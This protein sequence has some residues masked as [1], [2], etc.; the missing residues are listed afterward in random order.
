M[1]NEYVFCPRLFFLEWVDALWASNADVEEGLHRHRRVDSGGG[2]APLPSEGTLVAAR[3]VKLASEALGISAKLDLVEGVAGGVVP[4]DTKKG[5]PQADGTA[6]E[7]DAVQVCAQILLLREQGYPCDRGEIYYAETRQRVVV[8]PSPELVDRTLAVVSAAREIATQLSP[9]PPLD[10]SPKCARCSLVGICLPD[11]MHVLS[12]RRQRPPR[13][14]IAAD[15]DAKPLYVT[16][17]GAVIGQDGGRLVVSKRREELASVR[18]IDVAHISTYGNVQVTAQALRTLIERDIDVLYFSYGGWLLGLSTGP[19]AKNV[20][21]RIRQTTA[22]ARGQLD[23]P[24]RM[25]AGKI[26]NCRVL[27]RRN[28][29]DAMATVVDQLGNLATQAEDAGS[30]ASLLGIEGTAARLYFQSLPALTTR[31]NELPGPRFTGLR[32]RRPPTDAINCLLSFCYALLVKELLAACLAVGFDPYVGLFH[33]PRFGRPA[34][35]LDLAEEFRP[36]LADSVA[37]TVVNNREVAAADFQVRAGAVTLTADGRKAVIRAWE[38]RMSTQVR[39]PLLGY[40][41]TY[42]RAIELQ[43]RILAAHLAGELPRYEPLVTREPWP[44]ADSL[45]RTT[46]GT[47]SG[48]A[49]SRRVRRVMG[50]GFSTL[51]SSATCR[52]GRSS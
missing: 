18:L 11:E 32:N 21:L 14:L 29:G 44:G 7:A 13:R 26:R 28:G 48:S 41:L 52:N 16:E 6:W 42:R 35:A 4:V 22:A 39:H 12:G 46:S 45:S 38:R 20:M 3:S 51:S 10:G 27:L 2:A 19:P 5:R 30:A 15:S 34:L 50:T 33:R 36:L 25:V 43:A 49:R 23:A 17:Q 31:A 9:P 24:R 1:L 47:T 8:D 40:S 37:I